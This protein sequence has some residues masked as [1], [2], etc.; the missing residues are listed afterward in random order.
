MSIGKIFQRK[1][2]TICSKENGGDV[3]VRDFEMKVPEVYG[4]CGYATKRQVVEAVTI[5][6][7][8]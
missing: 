4:G 1:T 7:G 3:Q 2:R 5:Q 8:Q 6:H